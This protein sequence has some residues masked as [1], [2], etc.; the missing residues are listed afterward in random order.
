MSK[1]T[2]S[3]AARQIPMSRNKLYKS[4]INTGKISIEKNEKGKPQID[5]SELLRVFPKL[6]G[7]LFTST[8]FRTG[9]DSKNTAVLQE[10]INGLESVLFE[11]EK[12]LCMKDELIAN[13]KQQL[14]LLGFDKAPKKKRFW[15]F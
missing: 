12:L 10:R 11:K 1:L 8:A 2:I 15:F 4:Y 9:E 14:L 5:V 3:E 6:Q 13:Q 7:D